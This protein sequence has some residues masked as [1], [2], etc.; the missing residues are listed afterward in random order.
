MQFKVIK[1]E[2]DYDKAI[3]ELERLIGLHP[4]PGTVD[5]D[6]LELLSA[7]IGMYENENYLFNIPDPISAIEFVMDQRDLTPDD[8][9]PY[10][11]SITEVRRILSGE[12][13]LT[14]DMMRSLHSELGIPAN[15]LMQETSVAC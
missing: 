7:L 15:V 3:S 12:R 14:A 11:G 10:I 6:K 8:L 2:E 5:S 4:V 13:P 9:T 1:T